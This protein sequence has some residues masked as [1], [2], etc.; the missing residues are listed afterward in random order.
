MLSAAVLLWE[1]FIPVG[2][3]LHTGTGQR[4]VG[5][6]QPVL[7]VDVHRHRVGVA[8]AG[9]RLNKRGRQNCLPVLRRLLRIT[10]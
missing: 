1:Q 8:I 4:I 6:E 3:R 5:I 9:H 2:R 10:N 7:A